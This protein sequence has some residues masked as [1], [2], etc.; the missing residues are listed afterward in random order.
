M[1]E[2]TYHDIDSLHRQSEISN[3]CFLE[4]DRLILADPEG[5]NMKAAITKAGLGSYNLDV[6]EHPIIEFSELTAVILTI[7][8]LA[9]TSEHIGVVEGCKN[10]L[11]FCLQQSNSMVLAAVLLS[12]VYIDNTAVHPLLWYTSIARYALDHNEL[13]F[14]TDILLRAGWLQET[15]ND[16][17]DTELYAGIPELVDG[18]MECQGQAAL[19]KRFVLG[20]IEGR[21]MDLSREQLDELCLNYAVDTGVGSWCVRPLIRETNL[22]M[23]Q[24]MTPGSWNGDG[25]IRLVTGVDFSPFIASDTYVNGKLVIEWLDMRDWLA[26]EGG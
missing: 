22:G 25:E 9:H 3:G 21:H 11:V 2:Q 14:L 8:Q 7:L 18:Q 6:P 17:L 20:L 19:R 5:K 1:L 15:I 10:R 23:R 16:V 24:K 12:R 13:H 26:Y 4:N